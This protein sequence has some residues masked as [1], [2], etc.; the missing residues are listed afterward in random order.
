MAIKQGDK[1]KIEYTGTLDDGTLFDSSANHE[2][3]LEIEIG[4]RQ[5]IRGFENALIGMELNGEK[6]VHLTTLEAYGDHNAEL[7]KEVPRDKLPPE[8]LKEGML[9]AVQL[10]NGAQIPTKIT[11]VTPEM[12]TIDLNHP[13]AGKALNFHIKVVSIS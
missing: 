1:V 3:L 8:E 9:L 4:A 12:V 10:P 7:V 5:I 6:D 2:A 11:K 13:L